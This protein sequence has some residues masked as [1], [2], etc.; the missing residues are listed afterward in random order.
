MQAAAT[1]LAKGP[2]HNLAVTEHLAEV[3]Q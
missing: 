3:S 1:F 2:F